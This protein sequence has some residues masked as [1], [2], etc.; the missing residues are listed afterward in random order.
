MKRLSVIC[1][2]VVLACA[3]AQ[4]DVIYTC[5]GRR[6]VGKVIRENSETVVV[7]TRY[8]E[9]PLDRSDIV[10]IEEGKLPEEIYK[11]KAKAVDEN[12]AQ[13]HYELGV[14]CR[15]NKLYPEA[16]REFIK[17]IAADPD[18]EGARKKLGYRKID[19]EWVRG[20]SK[21]NGKETKLN[22]DSKSS[23]GSSA[24]ASAIQ[25][26]VKKAINAGSLSESDKKKLDSSAGLSK[27][28]FEEI[29]GTIVEWKQ[30]KV[31]S[32]T[33]FSAQMG[34]MNTFVHLPPGYNPKKSYPLLI[35]LTG[36]GGTGQRMRD[37][38]IT[39]KESWNAEVRNGY[40]IISPA[41]ATWWQWT[42][43]KKVFDMIEEAKKLYNIDTNRIYMTGF[44]N[45]GHSTWNLGMKQPHL[46][47]ALAPIAGGPV[48][49]AGR[50]LELK[51]LESLLN[52]PVHWVTTADDRICPPQI[53]GQVNNMYKRLGYTNLIHKQFPSGGHVPHIEYWGELCRWF[54][55]L[56]R[57]LYAK[58]F[59]FMSDRQETDTCYW[60]RAEGITRRATIKGE[61]VGSTIKLSVENATKVTV[62]L[63]DE[64]IDLDKPVRVE[65]NG[66]EEFSG[67]V[68][69]SAGVAVEEVLRRNDRNAI[70]AA[71][72]ELDVS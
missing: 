51:M 60:V 17:A 61:I 65:I 21:S 29:A 12:D 72:L 55:D 58:K 30:Y 41:A 38:W 1:I 59:I 31:H 35:V 69:R 37:A 32:Q 40:I 49:E 67:T 3:I 64:M 24:N 62:F 44:S 42:E 50:G 13:G 8:G 34:G 25:G 43:G 39:G 16:K 10:R 18:H 45:G 23:G 15:E 2:V 27:K 5:D 22:G 57:D 66:K 28:E 46:F 11:E 36:A 48:N 4:G 68:K 26:T 9:I 52:L 53:T 33:D 54:K 70:F 47:A 56:R 20:K 14:W 19:G 63:S 71:V 6:I 7:Q